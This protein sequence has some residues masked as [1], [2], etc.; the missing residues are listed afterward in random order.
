MALESEFIPN[1]AFSAQCVPI[2]GL[3]YNKNI[4]I[5]KPTI[6]EEILNI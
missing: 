2:M 1:L 4:I 3:V 6:N 5:V